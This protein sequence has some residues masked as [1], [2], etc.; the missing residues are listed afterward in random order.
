M[1]GSGYKYVEVHSRSDKWKEAQED[2][3]IRVILANSMAETSLTFQNL[4]Y[5]LDFN[6]EKMAG[7]C[8]TDCATLVTQPSSKQNCIQRRVGWAARAPASMSTPMTSVTSRT[9]R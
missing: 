6:H 1:T 9:R 5:V 4:K 2:T 7:V 3:S 8:N